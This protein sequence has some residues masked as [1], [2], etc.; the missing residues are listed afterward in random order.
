MNVTFVHCEVYGCKNITS[1]LYKEKFGAYCFEHTSNIKAPFGKQTKFKSLSPISPRR[2]S[3]IKESS[4]NSEEILPKIVKDIDFSPKKSKNKSKIVK[5]STSAYKS[6][7]KTKKSLILPLPGEE[8]KELDYS[9]PEDKEESV[10]L[11]SGQNTIPYISPGT[12]L[13]FEN[14]QGSPVIVESIKTSIPSPK[15]NSKFV[16]KVECCYCM[17]PYDISKVM[18]CG[19]MICPQCLEGIV[20]NPFC[21][22]CDKVLEGPFMTEKL[23]MIINIKYKQDL[24]N[25][26]DE[27][28]EFFPSD[29]E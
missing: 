27:E 22:F 3:L 9:S 2:I 29:E 28:E 1:D 5:K 15:S 7:F 23:S 6:V 13:T 16:K 21:E 19:H 26:V 20:R 8:N 24:E 4:V 12:N 18:N 10:H 25:L 11:L 17:D 14:Y